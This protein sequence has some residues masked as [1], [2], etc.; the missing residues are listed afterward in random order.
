MFLCQIYAV[1]IIV[2]LQYCLQSGRV[3]LLALLFFLRI[4]LEILG[5]LW[6]HISLRIS[7]SSSVKNIMGNFIGIVLNLYIASIV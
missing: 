2:A 3:M 4:A 1:L 7:C 6:L 5:L